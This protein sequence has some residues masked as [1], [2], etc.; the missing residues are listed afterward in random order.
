[1]F[2]SNLSMQLVP[3]QCH[4]RNLRAILKTGSWRTL[5]KAIRE[6]DGVCVHCGGKA[7]HC[8]EKWEWV[9]SEGKLIQRLIGLEAVCVECHDFMHFGRLATMGERGVERQHV[10]LD[11]VLKVLSCDADWLMTYVGQCFGAH[12]SLSSFPIQENMDLKWICDL[13][14]GLLGMHINDWMPIWDEIEDY[15]CGDEDEYHKEKNAGIPD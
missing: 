7:E 2:G 4:K 1:M 13:P 14:A 10:V 12:Q 15:L 11:H 8:H 3:S 5:S 6:R 9:V